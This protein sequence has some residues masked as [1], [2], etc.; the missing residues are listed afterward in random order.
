[1]KR[2]IS[3][4]NSRG[5]SA[6]GALIAILF[7]LCPYC[8]LAAE[9]TVSRMR[10]ED[11]SLSAPAS[12][13]DAL[14]W[15]ALS[16][17]ADAALSLKSIHTRDAATVKSV[18][19]P[20]SSELQSAVAIGGIAFLGNALYAPII[21]KGAN[22]Y[23]VKLSVDGQILASVSLGK[24][25]RIALKALAGKVFA[26]GSTGSEG[27][28]ADI[29]PAGNAV[30]QNMKIAHSIAILD[31]GELQQ[32]IVAYGLSQ[33]ADQRREVGTL[34]LIDRELSQILL[35]KQ[36]ACGATALAVANGQVFIACNRQNYSTEPG[37]VLLGYD[38]K[39]SQTSNYFLKNFRRPSLAVGVGNISGNGDKVFVTSVED[40]VPTVVK[41]DIANGEESPFK[42]AARQEMF[43]INPISVQYFAER[44]IVANGATQASPGNL[45]KH[46]FF[47]EALALNP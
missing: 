39:F 9:T 43:S 44:L 14:Y 10:S 20:L 41:V 4:Q 3:M 27:F 26:F 15:L 31:I 18:K 40:T 29:S 13:V 30:T 17:S 36:V 32:K 38:K 5:R 45:R 7:C 37:L 22:A 46:T 12:G 16:G 2:Q 21:T 8:T 23:V 28:I 35:I 34:T 42:V 47:I 33:Q 11:G 19:I 25:Q 6:F 1:M 24:A